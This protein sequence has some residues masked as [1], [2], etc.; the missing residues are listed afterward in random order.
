MTYHLFKCALSYSCVGDDNILTGIAYHV[1]PQQQLS[2]LFTDGDKKCH[3]ALISGYG[4][5]RTS[6]A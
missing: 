2:F 1:V 5:I 4:S 3:T 6:S